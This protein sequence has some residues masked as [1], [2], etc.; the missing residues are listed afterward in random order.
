MEILLP[1]AFIAGMLTAFTPCALPVLPII[2]ASS[3]EKRARTIGIIIGLVTFFTL[4]TMLLSSVVQATGISPDTIRTGSMLMLFLLGLLLIF[5]NIWEKLQNNIQKFWH[6]PILGRERSD[7]VGGFLSGATL[8]IV[9]TPCVG[10]VIAVV[11]TLTASSPLSS[12][13]WLITISYG[14]GIGLS[15]WFISIFSRKASAKLNFV[16]KNN[17]SLRQ[18]FGVVVVITAV[19]LYFG[20]DR[21]LRGWA[22]SVLPESWTQAG[23]VFQDNP[24]IQKQLDRLKDNKKTLKQSSVG[25][26]STTFD[27]EKLE[28]GCPRQDCI[29]SIDNPKFE[30]A[31]EANTWL[32]DSDVIFGINYKNVARAYPQR[33][34][35]WHEIVNDTISNDPIAITFC[36]LCG[37]AIA[38]ERKVNGQPVELGV[39]GKLFNSNLVMYDR[40]EKNYWQQ[41]TGEAITGPASERGEKLVQVSISTVSWGEWRKNFPDTQVLSKNTGLT[42]DYDRYPYGAY[43]ENDEIYFGVENTDIRLKLKEVVYGFDVDGAYKAYPES[44]VNNDTEFEDKI[45]DQTVTVTRSPSGEVKLVEKKSQKE[46]LPLRTFW[47]AWASFHPDSEIYQGK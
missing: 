17:T 26:Q 37:S 31:T 46:Y 6:P 12:T 2:L 30:P 22:L 38:F 42:R 34:L 36:P 13:A 39:S 10:P 8:G 15:L 45:G 40:I 1:V 44:A 3:V 35:N 32:K 28:Q 11:T 24:F 21:A 14:L 27:P 7:M 16:K 9:W 33:I 43:E 41:L 29:P 5:P 47:F 19:W 4:A 20:G 18:I 25:K 23:S